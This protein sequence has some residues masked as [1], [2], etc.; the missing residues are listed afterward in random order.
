MY[1][2]FF[3]Q[4]AAMRHYQKACKE[5]VVANNATELRDSFERRVDCIIND[6]E[7]GQLMINR[8]VAADRQEAKP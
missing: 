2:E 5:G 7:K 1:K 3:D 4:V 8:E 6:I